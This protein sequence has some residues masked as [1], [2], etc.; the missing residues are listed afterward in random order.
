MKTLLITFAMLFATA[1]AFAQTISFTDLRDQLNNPDEAPNHVFTAEKHFKL[2]KSA[3]VGGRFIFYYISN[4]GADTEEHIVTGI[5]WAQHDDSF[6]HSIYY[7]SK[8][9]IL[10]MNLVTQAKNAGGYRSMDS[11]AE[12]GRTVIALENDDYRVVATFIQNKNY[13]MEISQKK[14]LK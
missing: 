7:E 6:K 8:D 11:K 10:V 3:E 5:G 13:K 12:A 14:G 1:A 9:S 4:P 2:L